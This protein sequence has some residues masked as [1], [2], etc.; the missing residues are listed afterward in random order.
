MSFTAS[1]VWEIQTTGLDDFSTVSAVVAVGGTG[2]SVND[3]LTVV[4]GTSTTTATFTVATVA[5]G[6]VLTVTP[7]NTGHYTVKP[8]NPAAT[9]GGA[10]TCTLTI[11]WNAGGNGGGFD[12]GVAG[13]P[14]DGSVTAGNTSAPVFTSTAYAFVAGDVGAWIYIK[15]ATSSIPGW[16]KIVSVASNLAT[17]NAAIGSAVLAAGTP[18]TV[19]GCVTTGTTLSTVTWG[20][21]YSQGTAG[22]V[23]FTDILVGAVTTTFTSALKPVG[24]N[25]IGNIINVTSGA[26]VQRVVVVSTSTITATVDKTLGTAAQVGV[27]T[28]G[29]PLGSPGQASLLRVASNLAWIKSGTYSVT[30]ASTNIP[31]G[32]VSDAV[33]G[34]VKTWEGY[35]T[36]RGDLGTAPILQA[37]GISTAVLFT[38]TGA[39]AAGSILRNIT[40]DGASLT[41]TQGFSF[42]RR[43]VM[44][45]LRAI[46]CTNIGINAPTGNLLIRCSASNITGG[47]EAILF[48][49]AIGC[50]SY[51]NT[52]P[53]FVLGSATGGF[54]INCLSYGNTGAT[55]D[56]FQFAASSE[57]TV[58][59]CSAYGNGRDGFR[60]GTTEANLAVNCI[61]EGNGVTATGAGFNATS[62]AIGAGVT[63]LSCAVFGNTANS[64]V[65]VSTNITGP[66][67]GTVT[68]SA[69][70][71]VNATGGNF[72]LNNNS[73]AGAA[74]RAAGIPGVYPSGLTTGLIDIGAA[75]SRVP[76]QTQGLSG[77][78]EG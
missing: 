4:G 33:G 53:G 58:Q 15:A 13:F 61:A 28:L 63:L 62:A 14:T 32:C 38:V 10:G 41:S 49:Q 27:G 35:G 3:V 20:L 34:A 11:T 6:V 22:Q 19:T 26:T 78:I 40:V 30:S 9:T 77:G 55:S 70:F 29:G 66:Q 57:V 59:S 23:T 71:F 12:T 2:Y 25:Y 46:N 47:A 18:N 37:S 73:G 52:V 50:E 48:S 43:G 39:S 72:A 21:D 51:S 74:C 75:Q 16:Y 67:I 76:W 60:F 69:S 1:T 31:Q 54:V 42:A 44:Y 17:L 7:T 8:A 45:Q 5:A 65:N 56:G 68:G 36:V 24:K 64:S